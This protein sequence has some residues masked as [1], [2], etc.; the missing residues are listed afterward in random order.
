MDQNLFV[1][2]LCGDNQFGTVR[3]E[4]GDICAKRPTSW[5]IKTDKNEP[6]PIIQFA[7]GERHSLVIYLRAILKTFFCRF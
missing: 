5:C 4:N 3:G 2:G 1:M 7:C 6:D